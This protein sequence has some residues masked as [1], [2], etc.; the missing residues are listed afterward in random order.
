MQGLF[1]T[2]TDT[3][4]G[5]TWVGSRLTRL[6]TRHGIAVAPRKPVESG[7][8]WVQGELMPSDALH[9]FQAIDE[10]ESIDIICP[11]RYPDAVAPDQA[12]RQVSR[13]LNLDM[14]LKACQWDS[15][16]FLMIEGAGGFYSPIAEQALNAD[17][18][19]ALKLP[20]L[21][22]A[23]NQLGCQNHVL[24]TLEAITRRDL[25]VIAVILNQRSSKAKSNL[26]N[27]I[28]L[29]EKVSV[30]VFSIPYGSEHVDE[31]GSF[32]LDR[33]KAERGLN[34]VNIYLPRSRIPR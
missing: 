13:T 15:H 5:K 12:A 26:N 20:I 30:P 1:I 7:C 11:Y 25:Q 18:A 24:L 10:R 9:Y 31:L 6:L 29:K 23:A 19:Q 28:A 21:I 17:L 2:G 32:I 27:E 14:L 34:H 33:L 8:E 22:V 16:H 3:G 4:V